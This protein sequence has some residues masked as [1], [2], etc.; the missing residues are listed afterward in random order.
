MPRLPFCLFSL[1]FFRR[2]RGGGR[3]ETATQTHNGCLKEGAV[4]RKEQSVKGEEGAARREKTSPR[5]LSRGRDDADALARSLVD[6]GPL[7]FSLLLAHVIHSALPPPPPVAVVFVTFP[8]DSSTSD[9]ETSPPLLSL[10]RRF[11]PPPLRRPPPPPKVPPTPP[12]LFPAPPAPLRTVD[13]ASEGRMRH[14][15]RETFVPL[16]GLTSSCAEKRREKKD[17]SR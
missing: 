10:R 9:I 5:Q 11:R 12:L 3:K 16:G 13:S 1:E 15:P 8:A 6:L 14:R 4:E 7:F 17:I 2:P